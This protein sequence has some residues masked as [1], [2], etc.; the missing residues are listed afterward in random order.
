MGKA[1]AFSAVPRSSSVAAEGEPIGAPESFG[2]IVDQAQANSSVL[3]GLTLH[4]VLDALQD[5]LRCW[6]GICT[7]CH[8]PLPSRPHTT[9]RPRQT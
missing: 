2:A 6:T 5:V 3:T 1:P 7:T 9:S 4:Q 8:Q